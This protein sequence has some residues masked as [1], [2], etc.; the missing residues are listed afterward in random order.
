MLGEKR[1]FV[2]SL[3]SMKDDMVLHSYMKYLRVLYGTWVIHKP[4]L[5]LLFPLEHYSF[6][7]KQLIKHFE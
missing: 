2:L 3:P 6:S 4:S 7:H 5:N 1:I